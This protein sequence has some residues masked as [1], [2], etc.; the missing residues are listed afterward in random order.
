MDKMKELDRAIASEKD[1]KTLDRLRAVRSIRRFGISVAD[2]A[3]HYDVTEKTI[4]N[5][6]K[7]FDEDGPS[8]MG[9][10]PKSG[11]PP[12]V[13][14]SRMKK[15]AKRLFDKGELTTASLRDEIHRKT[16]TK[17]HLSYVRRTLR[18]FDFTAKLPD[19]VHANAA[20]DDECA[21]WYRRNMRR[22]RYYRK[23]GFKIGVQDEAIISESGKAH[24][25]LWAPRGIK[26]RTVITGRRNKKI[27]YGVLYDNGDQMF[28]FK[29]QFNGDM[30]LQFLRE[31]LRKTEKVFLIIDGA[32]Q[33]STKKVK[34]FLRENKH[35]LVLCTLPPA[36][37]HMSCTEKGW[38]ILRGA[39][40]ARRS[41]ASLAEKKADM[42]KYVRTK[43][44]NLDPYAF[45]ARRMGPGKYI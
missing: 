30:F 10:L 2:M 43:R 12:A 6:L 1:P 27:L 42:S 23:R 17:F 24:R 7:R 22:I 16:G 45:L 33:H 4:R 44:F 38:S 9:N 15:I 28:R 39:T 41:Y 21:A 11:R 29:D 19:I 14:I 5:W 13:K 31:L 36:S 32:R 26:L 40:E 18:R 35:R 3:N 34:E 20:S 37:P 25:K 8:G